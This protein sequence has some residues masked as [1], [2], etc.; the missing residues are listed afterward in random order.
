MREL[1]VRLNLDLQEQ[2]VGLFLGCKSFIEQK[3]YP[4]NTKMSVKE[5]KKIAVASDISKVSYQPYIAK[6]FTLI[7]GVLIISTSIIGAGKLIATISEP[8]LAPFTA[9]HQ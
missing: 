1:T 9:E 5:F 2:I 7:V 8:S 3:I 6:L 4:M